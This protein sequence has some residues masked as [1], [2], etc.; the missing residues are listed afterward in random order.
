MSDLSELTEDLMVGPEFKKEYGALQPE[1][2]IT[3]SLVCARKEAG[4]SQAEL[5]A[6]TGISQADLSRYE[7]G[8]RKPSLDLLKRI[9]NA[10]G[11]TL[12]IR[13]VP[14]K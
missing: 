1:R 6:K 9:A 2:D 12:R 10:L 14:N 11:A 3:S 7:N 8:S 5:S 4:L 13:I